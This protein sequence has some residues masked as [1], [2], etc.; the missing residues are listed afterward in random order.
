MSMIISINLITWLKKN[1][2]QKKLKKKTLMT[3]K[4]NEH[5]SIL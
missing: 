1:K 3:I 2:Q 5:L 4:K